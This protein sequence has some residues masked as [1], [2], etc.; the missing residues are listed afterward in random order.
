M[1]AQCLPVVKVA[2]MKALRWVEKKIVILWDKPCPTLLLQWSGS[3][4]VT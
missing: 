2:L 3:A 4:R 1:G